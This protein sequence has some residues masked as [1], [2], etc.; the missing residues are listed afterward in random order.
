[1]VVTGEVGAVFAN[2]EIVFDFGHVGTDAHDAFGEF[3]AEHEGARI[4]KVNAVSDL[5]GR[6]AEVHGHGEGAG[7]EDAEVDGKP[8]ETVHEQDT[9][10]VA[11][12]DAAGHEQIGETVGAGIKFAPCYLAA[13]F[14]AGHSLDQRKLLPCYFLFRAIG[15]IDLDQCDLVGIEARVTF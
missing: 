10:F 7:L 9:D 1:M 15:G 5:F 4:G 6:V 8:L 3:G 2:E 12:L 11:A 14:L 13:V